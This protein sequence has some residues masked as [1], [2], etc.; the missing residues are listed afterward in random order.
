MYSKTIIF[1]SGFAGVMFLAWAI[2]GTIRRYALI[3]HV[4][5][6]PNERSSHSVPT[7]RGG[8][9]AIVLTFLSALLFVGAHG[10]MA[11]PHVWAIAG[12]GF[13]VAVLGFLDDHGHVP[14]RWRLLGHF[15]AAGWALYWFGGMPTLSVAGMH[16]NSGTW[17]YMVAS[18]Y[19]VW[20]LNLYNF[21]DGIDGIASVEAICVA[22]G[23]A[24]LYV[25]INAPNMA[26]AP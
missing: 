19:L 22:V 26:I 20:M 11:W 25:F 12:A 16:L 15:L 13:W 21:M 5:D 17:G 10:Y 9:I 14:A 2:T 3:N 23:G 18:F 8:G 24:G 7:P 1:T 4:I 6:I